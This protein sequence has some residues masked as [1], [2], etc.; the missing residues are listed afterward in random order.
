MKKNFLRDDH[1]L[2]TNK[3]VRIIWDGKIKIALIMI[4]IL[5]IAYAEHER[6]PA[7]FTNSMNL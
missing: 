3:I 5:L 6:K 2:M 7:S 1:E 4:V